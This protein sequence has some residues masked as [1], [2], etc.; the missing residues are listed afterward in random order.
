MFPDV[1]TEEGLA[2]VVS[3]AVEKA[4]NEALGRRKP[5]RQPD[6]AIVVSS[7]DEESLPDVEMTAALGPPPK[8]CKYYGDNA[9]TCHGRHF[10]I[11]LT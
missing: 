2:R 10:R 5:S 9:M 8:R 4:V 7:D 3:Q 1:T 6:E 11:I